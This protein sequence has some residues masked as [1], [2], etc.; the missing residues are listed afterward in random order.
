MA[1]PLLENCIMNDKVNE[2]MIDGRQ[3]SVA[4]RLPYYWFRDPETRS[5]FRIP[6]YVIGGL[7][8]YRLSELSAWAANSNAVKERVAEGTAGE[9][10]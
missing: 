10:E 1:G 5:Q 4:L 3:A 9:D 8:R 2:S 7:I 6:H